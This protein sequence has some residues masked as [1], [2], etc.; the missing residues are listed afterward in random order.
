MDAVLE[1]ENVRAQPQISIRH[2]S[3]VAIFDITGYLTN[4]SE[5]A[6]NDAYADD[7]VQKVTKLL[8]NFDRQSFITSSGFGTIIK[9]LWKTRDKGQEMRIAHPATQVRTIFNTIGLTQ[10]IGVY[11]SEAEALEDF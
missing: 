8:L 6:I 4:E 7:E 10:S 5:E 11:A 3:D 9:L 2:E 1:E